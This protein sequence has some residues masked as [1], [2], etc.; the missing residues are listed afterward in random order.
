MMTKITNSTI[1]SPRRG[2]RKWFSSAEK[3]RFVQAS[4]KP[5]VSVG[6]IA[7]KYGIGV[8]SLVKWR[9]QMQSGAVMGIASG[10]SLV[11]VT[12]LK[13]LKQKVRELERLLGQ[14]TAENEVLKEFVVVAREKKLLSRQHLPEMDAFPIG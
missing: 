5:G 10:E 13:K 8:S 11:P 4:F 6:E 7:R 3:L 1:E 14:K 9:K 2:P 12:E